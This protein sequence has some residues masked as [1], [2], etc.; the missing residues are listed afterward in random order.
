MGVTFLIRQPRYLLPVCCFLGRE[1]R[2]MIKHLS[3]YLG[4]SVALALANCR[5]TGG[6]IEHSTS[7]EPSSI[8]IGHNF[9]VG[10]IRS[11]PSSIYLCFPW[12][13]TP[14]ACLREISASDCPLVMYKKIRLEEDEI[15]LSL[16]QRAR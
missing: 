5:V 16:S 7:P 14:M 13:F 1:G 6:C 9:P 8:V 2:E 12:L 15:V 10:S 3:S 4:S 11:R